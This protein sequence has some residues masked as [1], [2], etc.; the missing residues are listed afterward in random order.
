MEDLSLCEAPSFLDSSPVI[1]VLEMLQRSSFLP[2]PMDAAPE[3]VGRN[4]SLSLGEGNCA[5]HPIHSQPQSTHTSLI[6]QRKFS[7]KA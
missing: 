5:L 7:R 1:T 4:P 3:K 2:Y 6:I